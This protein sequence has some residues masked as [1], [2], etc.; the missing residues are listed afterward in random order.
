M[1][2]FMS[3]KSLNKG[4][5]SNLSMEARRKGGQHSHQ[6]RASTETNKNQTKEK[7]QYNRRSS[8]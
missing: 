5:G 1:E 4:R 2:A 6:G 7:K 3:R 8:S